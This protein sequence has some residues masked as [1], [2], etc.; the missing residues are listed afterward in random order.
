M[1]TRTTTRRPIPMTTRPRDTRTALDAYM[2]HHAAALELLARI[3]EHL[4]NH[5]DAPVE[6]P[7][8]GITWGHVGDIA[9][10]RKVL[11][12]ISDRLFSEG[13]D[14]EVA[15]LRCPATFATSAELDA[16]YRAAH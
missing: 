16:H 12:E 9:E 7:D 6:D 13:E 3:T 5:D 14:A 1:Q 10:T 4:A 8:T 11:Q 2:T 15:C